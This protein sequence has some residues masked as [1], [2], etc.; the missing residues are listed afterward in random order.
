MIKEHS[1]LIDGVFVNGIALTILTVIN[2]VL[3]PLQIQ[4][5]GMEGFGIIVIS[6]IFSLQGF[7][8]ILDFGIPG[9]LTK[10][11]S[12]LKS[13]QRINDIT[14]LFNT[15]LALFG[16]IG[17]LIGSILIASSHTLA[18]FFV[19]DVENIKMLEKGLQI[20]FLSYIWQFPI[21]ILRS[22]YQGYKNFVHI[23]VITVSVELARFFA[24]LVL[25]NLDY[26]FEFVI[27]ANALVTFL[28]FACYIIWCPIP[29]SPILRS[30]NI[31]SLVQIWPLSKALWLG[32]LSGVFFNNSDKVVVSALLGPSVVSLVEIFTKIPALINRM[33]GLV[34]STTIP[35]V[36]GIDITKE[37]KKITDIYQSGFKV[38][39]SL[40]LPAILILLYFT[41]EILDKWVGLN[42]AIVIDSMRLMLVWCML[43]PLQFGGNIIIGLEIGVR[44]LIYYRIFQAIF[45][46]ASLS[47]LILI[48]KEY[49]VPIS[50]LISTIPLVFLMYVFKKEL[51]IDLFQQM[52]NYGLVFVTAC[53]PIAIHYVFNIN[54]NF[55]SDILISIA[56]ILITQWLFIYLLLYSKSE[57][58]IIRS[59]FL[60]KFRRVVDNE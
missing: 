58:I 4:Y 2:L 22:Q 57:R 10:Q 12:K 1:Q 11:I 51:K 27:M 42:N 8:S 36:A 40:L 32:R 55:T 31:K 15:S 18:V 6:T 23:Q 52:S 30:F 45:K 21:L 34:V 25:L 14:S 49:A 46:V 54:T 7:V 28:G 3:I 47:A 44:K 33:L 60:N 43:V 20:F 5:L 9:A 38:Y 16:L 48:L 56:I 19:T 13:Q 35:V 37:Y 53:I 24:I 59:Y 17:L 41:P 39:V 29:L 26:G 50:Y